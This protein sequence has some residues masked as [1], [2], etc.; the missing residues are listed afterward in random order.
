MDIM[1]N[2]LIKNNTPK[3]LCSVFTETAN[4]VIEK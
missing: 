1:N 2:N 3:I 4:D